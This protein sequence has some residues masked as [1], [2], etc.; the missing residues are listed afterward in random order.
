MA[1][2]RIDGNRLAV[3]VEDVKKYGGPGRTMVFAEIKAGRLKARKMGNRTI[4]LMDDLVEY[5][6]GLSLAPTGQ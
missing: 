2:A 1:T 4:I 5:L 6:E 3:D